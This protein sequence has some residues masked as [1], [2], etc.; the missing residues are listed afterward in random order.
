MV[1]VWDGL[2]DK[3]IAITKMRIKH[4]EKHGCGSN[5]IADKRCLQKQERHRQ[6]R[7]DEL[8]I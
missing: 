8:K 6:V 7:K 2:I 5:V 1:R 4:H 3:S